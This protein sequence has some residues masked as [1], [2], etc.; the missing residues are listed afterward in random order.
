MTLKM[1]TLFCLAGCAAG[2]PALAAKVDGTYLH[3]VGRSYVSPHLEWGGNFA[4]KPLRVLFITERLNAREAAENAQRMKMEFRNFTM[5]NWANLA[6]T[7]V[8]EGT[9]TGTSPAEKEQELRKK[10]E[11]DYDVI[12]FYRAWFERS[13]G[14]LGG[15]HHFRMVVARAAFGR[16]EEV[17]PADAV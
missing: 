6:G 9:M 10:L 1:L 2:T 8:Y 7:D 14:R 5:L 17:F 4:G 11:E 16:H 3:E 12:V 13:P 15:E